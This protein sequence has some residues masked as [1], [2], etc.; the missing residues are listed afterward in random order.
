[1]SA[2][3]LKNRGCTTFVLGSVAVIAVL[4]LVFWTWPMVVAAGVI[5]AGV[6]IARKTKPSG[7]AWAVWFGAGAVVLLLGWAGQGA[8]ISSLDDTTTSIET[9]S[10]GTT[11]ERLTTTTTTERRRENIKP[12]TTRRPTSTTITTAP[13][14]TVPTT[15]TTLPPPPPPPPP[16]APPTTVYVPPPTTRVIITAPPTTAAASGGCHPS[17]SPCVPIASD[18][19]CAGG[20]GNGPAYA[21]GPVQVIGPDVYGLDGDGDGVGCE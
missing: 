15:V 10:V 1:M 7:P 20:S 21:S 19:D 11:I 2:P 4:S 3:V 9:A 18:V 14:T 8:W 16:T 17:Y 13:P 5:A 12:T 6:A